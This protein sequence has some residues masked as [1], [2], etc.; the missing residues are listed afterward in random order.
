MDIFKVLKSTNKNKPSYW[1]DFAKLI[2]GEYSYIN[3]EKVSFLYNN[4]IIS[5]DEYTHYAVVN[6]KAYEQKYI[7]A[8]AQ[9]PTN[10]DLAFK[11]TSQG[12]LENIRKLFGAK[13]IIIGDKQFD[14][15]YLI[16]GNSEHAIQL[17][18]SN[19]HIQ[20]KLKDTSCFHFEYSANEG[21]FDEK[22]SDG[23]QLLYF[24]SKE[25]V[26]STEILENTATLF[27]QTI[28]ELQHLGLLINKIPR[29]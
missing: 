22:V 4:Y 21:V 19:T 23:H 9:L 3:H 2:N 14:K 11:L 16:E 13:E 6:T 28:D 10:N 8:V 20:Q 15:Q 26:Q 18:F 27:C 5:I 24:L 7:R 12:I 17:I 1:F 29:T 25:P